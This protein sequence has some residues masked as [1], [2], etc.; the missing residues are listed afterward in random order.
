MTGLQKENQ[1][2]GFWASSWGLRFPVIRWA[3]RSC[4]WG[5]QSG[6]AQWACG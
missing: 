5:A 2:E 4:C 3:Q 1:H 6:W